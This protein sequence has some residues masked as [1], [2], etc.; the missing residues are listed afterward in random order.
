MDLASATSR[1]AAL[2]AISEQPLAYASRVT[3]ELLDKLIAGFD[4][5]AYLKETP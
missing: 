2:V 3:E 1:R 4:D 5:L